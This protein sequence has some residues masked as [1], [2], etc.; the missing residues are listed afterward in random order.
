M[1]FVDAAL[2]LGL[3]GDPETL[4]RRLAV[5]P[6][7]IGVPEHACV[8]G[9]I[10]T[11]RQETHDS[12]RK[13]KPGTPPYRSTI[14]MR[15]FVCY[16]GA[17]RLAFDVKTCAGDFVAPLLQIA[18]AINY[19]GKRGSFIQYL[20]V[21][22]QNHLG[23]V[24]TQPADDVGLSARGQ[25]ATLDDFGEQASFHALN[26]FTSAALRRGIDRRFVETLV[27]LTVHNSGPGFVHYCATGTSE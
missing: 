16:Q 24:F 12:E 8:T 11:V 1:A 10:Q 25:R 21:V 19:L 17:L 13:R 7:R 4:V 3:A 18:P 6:V 2:R 27:P 9:T 22:R 15:E 20:S 14:A 26:S 23:P 5:T